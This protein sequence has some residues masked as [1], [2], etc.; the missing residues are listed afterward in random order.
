[1]ILNC[2][3]EHYR[4]YK[5]IIHV[6]IV[7]VRLS[8]DCRIGRRSILL[9][10]VFAFIIAR[11]LKNKIKNKKKTAL[12][13]GA[14]WYFEFYVIVTTE[15]KFAELFLNNDYTIDDTRNRAI[16]ND[17]FLFRKNQQ[18]GTLYYVTIRR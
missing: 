7:D 15:I 12:T 14:T 5:C 17:Y 16:N 3:F 6:G 2:I 9:I 13:H 10:F 4:C 8:I 18:F 1:M 11:R